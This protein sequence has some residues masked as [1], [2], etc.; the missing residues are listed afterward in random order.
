MSWIFRLSFLVWLVVT[1]SGCASL[2][3]AG[4]GHA[5]GSLEYGRAV[6]VGK[7]I[8][9]KGYGLYSYVLFGALPNDITRSR[10]LQV[11]STW[12]DGIL[13][14]TELEDRGFAKRELNV[15]YVLLQEPPPRELARSDRLSPAEVEKVSQWIVDHYD[16]ARA[17]RILNAFPGGHRGGPYLISVST[18]LTGAAP[19]AGQYLRQDLSSVPAEFIHK[20]ITEFLDQA[21]RPQCWEEP[22]VIRMTLRLRAVLI[23]AAQALPE[24]KNALEDWIAW[25]K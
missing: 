19:A 21:G 7:Q 9:E 22:C 20:W 13:P 5:G 2:F 23:E 8:E 25:V 16:Y 1:A 12:L 6:L 10:Y 4:K 11:I 18:P 3:P 24:V 17:R 15:T 14:L